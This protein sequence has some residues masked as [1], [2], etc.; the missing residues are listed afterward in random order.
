MLIVPHKSQRCGA[1][2][3]IVR[4]P[5]LPSSAS[6]DAGS[7]LLAERG[8]PQAL[9]VVIIVIGLL[10]GWVPFVGSCGGLVVLHGSVGIQGVPFDC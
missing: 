9:S 3:F 7:F 1:G 2:R 4:A 5:I 8:F 10:G 6:P